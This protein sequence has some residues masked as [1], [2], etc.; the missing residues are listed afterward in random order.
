MACEPRSADVVAMFA[1]GIDDL[2]G[3]CF[4]SRI[5]AQTME[6]SSSEKKNSDEQRIAE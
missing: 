1:S 3:L 6:S 4:A 2:D 5:E